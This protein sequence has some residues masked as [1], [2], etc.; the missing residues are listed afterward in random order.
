MAHFAVQNFGL[1]FFFLLL[2]LEKQALLVGPRDKS[3][4]CNVGYSQKVLEDEESKDALPRNLSSSLHVSKPHRK[5]GSS[6]VRSLALV[7]FLEKLPSSLDGSVATSAEKCFQE[8][9]FS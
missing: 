3:L 7:S 5:L 6:R 2:L 4:S 1:F 9:E 8:R